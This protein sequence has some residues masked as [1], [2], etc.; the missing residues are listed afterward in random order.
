M[1]GTIIENRIT[2][3]MAKELI[4]N[5]LVA[6]SGGPTAVINAS[7]AGVITEA[8]NYECIEE[9]YGS[10]N[11]IL[12]VLNEDLVDLAEESQQNIRGLRYTPGSA[13]G[14]CRY[15]VKNDVD[16]ERIL[17]VLISHNIRYF[18]YI[19][20]NDSQDTAAKISKLAD[21]KG[22]DL[23][24]IGIPKTVDNDLAI[25]DHC[26]GYGSAIKYVASVVREMALDHAAMGQRKQVSIIEVMGRS[27]G[28]IAA[29]ATL[30]KRRGHPEDAPHIILLPEVPFSKDKF[31]EHVQRT[32]STKTFCVVVVGEGLRDEVGNY[33]SA[34]HDHVDSFGH[35]NLGGVG[36]YLK[37]LVSKTLGIKALSA[38]LGHHQ[39]CAAHLSSLTDNQEAFQA[40][41]AAVQ[42]TLEGVSGKMITL[43]RVD[44][45]E[46]QCETGLAD[47]DAVAN[48]IKDFPLEWIN[49]D[50]VSLSYQFSKYALP[51]IKGQ[52]EVP[53]DTGLPQYVTLEMKA[54]EKRLP[55]YGLE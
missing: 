17:S 24:V 20:G 31:L 4:G 48:G 32:L 25:T 28:W 21:T 35:A 8:L 40:G 41:Q 10:A 46:Y 19:G 39:R 14:T 51:L 7:L 49:E 27:T 22:Y 11:G 23:R 18:F 53:F 34:S 6:Q 50:Q 5:V 36:D 2:Y 42:K 54:I 26:P 44:A 30:A 13:L 16:Y 43:T 29:G 12:G 3:S 52:V 33:V 1:S 9:I 37:E 15:K 47:L 38:R 55:S 45:D